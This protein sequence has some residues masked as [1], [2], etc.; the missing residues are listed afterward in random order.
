MVI[1]TLSDQRTDRQGAACCTHHFKP[2]CKAS[3]IGIFLVALYDR[4][5]DSF[6]CT[7]DENLGSIHREELHF[8]QLSNTPEQDLWCAERNKVS[9]QKLWLGMGKWAC[10]QVVWR[11]QNEWQWTV[12][13]GSIR[14]CSDRKSCHFSQLS[15]IRATL[16]TNGTREKGREGVDI[17]T[18]GRRD[19]LAEG[20]DPEKAC[21]IADVKLQLQWHHL[22]GE[23]L[24][25]SWTL[26]WLHRVWNHQPCSAT[27]EVPSQQVR[28][29][30]R[31][32][33]SPQRKHSL[34]CPSML[35][36]CESYW[37]RL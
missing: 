14:H 30:T 4:G 21:E 29:E 5:F 26:P 9:L 19:C 31:P 12:K 32:H 24:H 3:E 8:L 35:F 15:N 11:L 7:L 2:V 13:L 25:L 23:P 18:Q 20:W 10:K 34:A 6:P 28:I 1:N 22:Q 27:R 16:D 17:C 37:A 33:C 36:S